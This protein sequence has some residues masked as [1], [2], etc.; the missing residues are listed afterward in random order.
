M[1]ADTIYVFRLPELSDAN[2]YCAEKDTTYCG[3]GNGE[4]FGPYMIVDDLTPTDEEIMNADSDE[5]LIAK[6][7][8]Y[9]EVTHYKFYLD[10][11]SS[12]DVEMIGPK[13]LEKVEQM[14]DQIAK[15]YL[16]GFIKEW[17]AGWPGKD[18]ASIVSRAD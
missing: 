10:A 18:V 8:D 3:I 9:L 12:A 4:A 11:L 2:V 7:A 17:V 13:L 16:T 5:S 6:L 14:Q 15:V 1:G